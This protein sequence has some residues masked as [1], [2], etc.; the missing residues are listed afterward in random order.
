M[1]EVW[2]NAWAMSYVH[3]QLIWSCGDKWQHGNR[4]VWLSVHLRLFVS[5]SLQPFIK[6]F[7]SYQ[8]LRSTDKSQTSWLCFNRLRFRFRETGLKSFDVQE[9]ETDSSTLVKLWCMKALFISTWWDWYWKSHSMSIFD[10]NINSS[11]IKRKKY[12]LLVINWFSRTF[13]QPVTTRRQ[14]NSTPGLL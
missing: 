6:S 10:L 13:I 4:R 1:G 14:T 3:Q 9:W 8:Q 5:L 12:N 11:K 2:W 7:Q